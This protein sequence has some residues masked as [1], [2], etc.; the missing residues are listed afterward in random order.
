MKNLLMALAGLVMISLT[1]C[2][3]NDLLLSEKKLNEKIQKSWKVIFANN[4]D[5]HE[6][7]SFNG[8]GVAINLKKYDAN[9]NVTLDTTL[10]G[11]YSIDAKLTKAYVKLSGFTFG[12]STSIMYTNSNFKAVDLNRAWTIVVLEN[13]V[14]YLSATDNGGAIRS[15]E[16]VKN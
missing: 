13:D 16:Y 1:G 10:L 2:E 5:S 3:Q 12:D 11:S 4:N 14:M 9:S 8:G 6:T 7:W 15:L